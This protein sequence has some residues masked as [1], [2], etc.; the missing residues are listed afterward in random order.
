MR[1]LKPLTNE[2]QFP[3]QRRWSEAET[4]S[5]ELGLWGFPGGLPEDEDRVGQEASLS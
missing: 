4:H 1:L 5:R 3:A 2:R